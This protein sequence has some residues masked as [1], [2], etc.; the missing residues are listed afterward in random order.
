MPAPKMITD[1]IL[2]RFFTV[3]VL[4]VSLRFSSGVVDDAVQIWWLIDR[5]Y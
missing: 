3:K 4:I 5:I 2:F 1:F